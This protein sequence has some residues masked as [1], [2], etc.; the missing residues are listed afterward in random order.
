MGDAHTPPHVG[1]HLG[2]RE[3]LKEGGGRT[4][5]RDGSAHLN[6]AIRSNV[7]VDLD[8][9]IQNLPASSAS[10]SL[11]SEAVADPVRSTVIPTL[12]TPHSA[13]PRSRHSPSPAGEPSP[14]EM[15]WPAA[16]QHKRLM[17]KQVKET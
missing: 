10:F 1:V 9:D 8:V 14:H 17:L 4:V 3:D 16:N 5:G 6:K 15:C 7:A 12:A 2:F 11:R 13:P